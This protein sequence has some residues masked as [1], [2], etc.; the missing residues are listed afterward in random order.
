MRA[1][2]TGTSPRTAPRAPCSRAARSPRPARSPAPLRAP[3]IEPW[4]RP[5]LTHR[6]Q[7]RKL[8]EFAFPG[9]DTMDD[10]TILDRITALVD[11]EKRLRADA[12][13]APE[14][15]ADRLKSLGEQ[16]D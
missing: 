15:N 3:S 2:P 12:D 13:A 10:Q 4:H 6:E 14:Q 8:L 9:A 1:P 11:E 16:L 7:A 5:T